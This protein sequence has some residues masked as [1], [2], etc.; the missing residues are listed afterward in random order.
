MKKLTKKVLA[1]L[2]MALVA[3]AL[4]GCGESG[5]GSTEKETTAPVETQ[6]QTEA[7]TAAPAAD[8]GVYGYYDAIAYSIDLSEDDTYVLEPGESI[9][10]NEDGSLDAVIEGEKYHFDTTLKNNEFFLDGISVGAITDDGLVYL[11]INDDIRYIYA[12]EGMVQ[13]DEWKAFLEE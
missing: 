2:L 5:G 13:W 8:K 11:D 7:P 1:L 12:R 10:I 3:F 4:F 9:Y 6:K